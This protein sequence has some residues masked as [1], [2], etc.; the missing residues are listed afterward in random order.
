MAKV[1]DA[2]RRAEEERKR[3]AGDDVSPVAPL[4]VSP[5]APTPKSRRPS[6]W[7]RFFTRRSRQRAE[8]GGGAEVNKRRIA[9][10]QPDSY[11]AEQF[12]ALRGR[13]DAI[14]AERRL[15]TIVVT[16]A[17]PGEIRSCDSS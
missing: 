5:V 12:R 17:F 9:L 8:S 13:I 3:R 14:A 6:L 15:R 7:K 2:L 16:S 4:D 1:Y 11:V 10:I